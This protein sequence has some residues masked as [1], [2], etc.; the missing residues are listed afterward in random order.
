MCDGPL[1]GC[2]ENRKGCFLGDLLLV[3]CGFCKERECLFEFELS[4]LQGES[5]IKRQ[6]DPTRGS[7]VVKRQEDLQ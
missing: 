2:W 1:T 3:L 7:I 4:L 6:E 5:E